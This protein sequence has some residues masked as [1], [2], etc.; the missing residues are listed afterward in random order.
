MNKRPAIAGLLLL[1][2]LPAPAAE[3]TEAELDPMIVQSRRLDAARNAISPSLGASRTEVDRDTIQ[4]LPQGEN[5]SLNQVLLQTPGVVQEAFGDIHVRGDHRNLQYRINGVTLPESIG[6]FGQTLDARAIRSVSLLTGAL[7]AQYGYRTAGII[8]ITLRSGLTDPGGS[9][10]LYGGAFGTLQP[11]ASYGGVA[12]GWEYFATGSFLRNDRGIDNPVGTPTAPHNTTQQLRGLAYAA[13]PL[14]DTTRVSVI[15]GSTI[16]RFEVPNRPGLHPAFT[17]FGQSSFDSATLRARQ[18]E[19]TYFGVASL[20]KSLGDVDLQLSSFT[21]FSSVHYT[22]DALGDLLFNGAA[23]EVYRNSLVNGLQADGVWRASAEHVLRGG[24]FLSRDATR[25]WTR[26]LVLPLDAAGHPVDAP[27]T[28]REKESRAG[29]LYGLYA[30]DEWRIAETVTLNYGARFDYMDLNTSAS[31]LSPR[32]NAVWTPAEGTTIAAGYARYFTPPP[33][34][35]SVS[36]NP[37]RL[38]GTT[39]AP[40][41]TRADP[42][43]PERSHYF[44]LGINQRVTPALTLGVEGYYRIAEDMQ[45]L[46]QFGRAYV[47]SPYNYK[48]GRVYGTEFS[49]NWREGPLLAYA[50]LAL[51]RSVGRGLVSNQYFWTAEEQAYVR[52]KW[53]RTDHDQLITGSVGLGYDVWQGGRASTTTTYGSGM[54]RGF[55]NTRSMTPYVTQNLGFTQDFEIERGRWTARVDVLNLFDRKYQLRDGTGI[56]VGAP[57]YGLRRGIYVGLSRAI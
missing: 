51:S 49:A 27:F 34:E 33:Q 28:I 40:G 26:S 24:A 6:G 7:P 35:L 30:Q 46:G 16:S 2:A 9:I 31:Q 15:A 19:R 52:R 8:D 32:L 3:E 10:G 23:A 53:V 12:A 38:L 48:E 45:D 37:N 21:R 5:A 11:S 18:W 43:R 22:P 50:N 47:F 17:A 25:N 20:Q 14:D 42:V 1:I 29:W 56:G 36:V 41:V 55:A 44:N 4:R 39:L 13:R 54:R 57:Q